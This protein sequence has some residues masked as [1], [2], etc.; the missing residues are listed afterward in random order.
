[1]HFIK[2]KYKSTIPLEIMQR[3]KLGLKCRLGGPYDLGENH[4]PIRAH[5]SGSHGSNGPHTA[6]NQLTRSLGT[7]EKK[8]GDTWE[9]TRAEGAGGAHLPVGQP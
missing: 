9:A 8:Q 1:M 5:N 7:W 6:P 4:Q 2:I 3:W